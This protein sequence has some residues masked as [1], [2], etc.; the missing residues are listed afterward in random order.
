ML[1]LVFGPEPPSSVVD[2]RLEDLIRK[3]IKD[4]TSSAQGGEENYGAGSGDRHLSS[5]LKRAPLQKKSS[6]VG[7]AMALDE[8]WDDMDVDG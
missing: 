8:S 1:E 3:S 7:S 6:S 4:A 2:A 5:A